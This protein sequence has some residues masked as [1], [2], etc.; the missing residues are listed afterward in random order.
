M[1]YTYNDNF[2]VGFSE[3]SPE[4]HQYLAA[5]DYSQIVNAA[6]QP[7][8]EADDERINRLLNS[9]QAI[10]KAQ[11]STSGEIRIYARSL[12]STDALLKSIHP[13]I[14]DE[15][16]VEVIGISGEKQNW[17]RFTWPHI[18]IS[19]RGVLTDEDRALL[20]SDLD[21]KVMIIMS[22][23]E[24]RSDMPFYQ[25]I[26]QFIRTLLD[27]HI[28]LFAV[29]MSYQVLADQVLCLGITPGQ[30]LPEPKT[31]RLRIGT[32]IAM[33]TEYGK[34]DPVFSSVT[35]AFGVES[36]NH[37]RIYGNDI[38]TDTPMK[39]VQVLARDKVTNE[40]VAFK[41][42][43]RCWAIQYHPELKKLARHSKGLTQTSIAVGGQSVLIPK[44][45]HV[46]QAT[47]LKALT[48]ASAGL[49]ERYHISAADLQHFFHPARRIHNVGDRLTLGML[50]QAVS[51]KKQQL[52][53]E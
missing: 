39:N 8:W 4:E 26:A 21:A 42:G 6:G 40:I 23:G 53:I 29:C 34:T 36:W 51:A 43:D 1:Q 49:L 19:D 32:Q 10:R 15:Q 5:T 22:G 52:A 12:R 17:K 44:G 37:Y 35:P 2:P 3:A 18:R 16:F 27:K 14:R 46:Y 30:N 45:M 28:F 38:Q 31:G 33:L 24:G 25:P 9:L 41:V 13:R 7:E 20:Y 50:E 47:L 11:G 48:T